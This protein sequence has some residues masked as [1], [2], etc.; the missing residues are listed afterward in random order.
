MSK[1]ALVVF[2]QQILLDLHTLNQAQA[3]GQKI[4][5]S[6]GFKMSKAK[7]TSVSELCNELGSTATYAAGGGEGQ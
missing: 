5:F 7:L 6:P 1:E 3:S 4:M 2:H